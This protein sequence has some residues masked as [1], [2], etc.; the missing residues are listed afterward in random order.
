VVVAALLLL[1][2]AVGLLLWLYY[3]VVPRSVLGWVLLFVI[4]IPSWLFL[5]WLGDRVFSAR[6]FSRIGRA[7]RIALA[8]PVMILLLIVAA[9]IIY[10]GQRV[11]AG[12]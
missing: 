6:V 3:P 2:L 7:A 9:Y 8:V 10:L 4:G 1:A 5:E 11:I 12:S